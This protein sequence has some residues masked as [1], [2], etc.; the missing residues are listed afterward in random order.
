MRGII[1]YGTYIPYHRLQRGAITE[2]LGAG[3]GRG[4]RA[5]AAYDEDATSMAV[6]ASRHLVGT[7][8][9]RP[10]TVLFATATPPYLDKTNANVIHAALDL[11]SSVFA[12]DVAGSARCY[13]AALRQAIDSTRPTLVV[14]ADV[15]TGRP[16][17]ADEANCG[18]GAVALLV[19]G[20]ADGPVIAEWIG[21]ASSTHEFLDRWRLPAWDHSR[22]WEERFGEV[23]YAPLMKAAFDAALAD[24]GLAAADIDHLDLEVRAHDPHLALDG[25][26]DGLTAYRMIA[27]LAFALLAPSGIAAVEIGQSQAHDVATLMAEVGLAVPAPAKADL[28]GVPRVVTARKT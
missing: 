27:P 19:G 24:A 4:T 13:D 8:D 10:D 21:G 26:A 18:D 5:V 25:G 17:S 2:A 15:R 22:V 3:G 16:S 20:D 7:V 6:E 14:A 1:G 11:P 23:T 9:A 28:G 12:A